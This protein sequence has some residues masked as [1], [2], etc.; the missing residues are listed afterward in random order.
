MYYGYKRQ[1]KAEELFQ[2]KETWKTNVMWD[3]RLNPEP[4]KVY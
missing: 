2:T 1:E 3:P 4:E